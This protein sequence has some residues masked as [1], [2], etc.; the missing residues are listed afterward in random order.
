[1]ELQLEVLNVFIYMVIAFSVLSLLGMVS[2]ANK[3]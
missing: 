3:S 1:M 2:I